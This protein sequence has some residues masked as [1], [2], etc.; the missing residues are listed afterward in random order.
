MGCGV[1]KDMSTI[2]SI[3][4]E[5]AAHV[6]FHCLRPYAST[7]WG[8]GSEGTYTQSHSYSFRLLPVTARTACPFTEARCVLGGLMVHVHHGTFTSW[9]MNIM[10]HVHHGKFTSW[11]I[12]IM[13]HVHHG[14][15]T[16]W[17]MYIMEHAHHGTCTSWNMYIMEHVHCGTC[18]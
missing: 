6:S 5:V 2:T 9:N 11:N 15:C 3:Q 18:T 12:Y 10:E 1:R 13:E 4:F 14:T 8:E 7:M 17:N 16:S